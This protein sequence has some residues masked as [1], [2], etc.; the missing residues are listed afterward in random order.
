M[1][2]ELTGQSDSKI[3]ITGSIFERKVVMS[4]VRQGSVLVSALF[5]IFVGDMGSGTGC[6]FS[7]LSSNTELCGAVSMLEGRDVPSRGTW[8]SWRAGPVQTS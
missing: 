2:K 5:M 4:G 6:S 7:K 3:E 1:D 8:T